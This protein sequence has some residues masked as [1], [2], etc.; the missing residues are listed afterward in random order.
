V[1]KDALALGANQDH[2]AFVLGLGG[3]YITVSQVEHR[4]T[5]SV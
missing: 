5:A 4:H 3:V 2:V 1:T